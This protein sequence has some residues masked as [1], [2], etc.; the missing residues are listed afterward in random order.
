VT[1][2]MAAVTVVE[3][4]R[5]M[6]HFLTGGR[7]DPVVSDGEPIVSHRP[8]EKRLIRNRG[9]RGPACTKDPPIGVGCRQLAIIRVVGLQVRKQRAT[10]LRLAEFDGLQLGNHQ[11]HLSSPFAQL[12]DLSGKLLNSVD[13]LLSDNPLAFI[14]QVAFVPAL[15]YEYGQNGHE[16]EHQ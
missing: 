12:V 11:Q 13:D 3:L 8:R 15:D 1:P 14:A 10:G 5:E 7:I 4:L 6:Y 2:A 16:D 9:C